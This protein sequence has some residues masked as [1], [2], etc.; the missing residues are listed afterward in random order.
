M[1]LIAFRL[2]LCFRLQ[3][4]QG[5][6]VSNHCASLNR[7]SAFSLFQTELVAGESKQLLAFVLIAFRLFLCFRLAFVHAYCMYVVLSV[8]IAFRLFLCFRPDACI[9][10]GKYSGFVLI[11]FRLFLCF[12]LPASQPPGVQRVERPFRRRTVFEAVGDAARDS[13]T[14]ETSSCSR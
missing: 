4:R 10:S 14:C 5:C 2:F 1:V 12:R 3:R 8:L 13:H 6:K 9:R 7:L 11:A